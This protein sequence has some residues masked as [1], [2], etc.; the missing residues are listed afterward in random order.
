MAQA[1]P[2]VMEQFHSVVP[3]EADTALA[4]PSPVLG[5]PSLVCKAIGRADGQA[6]CL[7]Y[8]PP[9]QARLTA[10]ASACPACL[11]GGFRLRIS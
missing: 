1:V 11:V 3:L 6:V 7:R 10:L 9:L 5:V 4:R 2:G 8:F